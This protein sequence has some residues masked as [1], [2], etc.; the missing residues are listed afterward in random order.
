VPLTVRGGRMVR[1]YFYLPHVWRQ[2][3]GTQELQ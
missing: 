3:D 2:H 1:G